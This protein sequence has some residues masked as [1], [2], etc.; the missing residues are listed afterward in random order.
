MTGRIRA[1]GVMPCARYQRQQETTKGLRPYDQLDE[2]C[3]VFCTGLRSVCILTEQV[4][5]Q[6]TAERTQARCMQVSLMLTK[7]KWPQSGGL[8]GCF[9]F[10]ACYA[11]RQA[12]M[13]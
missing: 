7:P 13:M 8:P 1:K 4:H 9:V 3:E 6:H 12:T 2:L 11:R 5:V 10:C